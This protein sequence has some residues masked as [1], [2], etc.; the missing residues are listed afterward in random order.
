MLPE[1]AEMEPLNES[2][3]PEHA[4]SKTPSKIDFR[5]K[6]MSAVMT[7]AAAGFLVAIGV[8]FGPIAACFVFLGSGAG[9]VL[10]ACVY[11]KDKDLNSAK[12]N[13]E[14]GEMEEG[15]RGKPLNEIKPNNLNEDTQRHSEKS[16]APVVRVGGMKNPL[17]MGKESIKF[18][19]LSKLRTNTDNTFS[20][21][22]SLTPPRRDSSKHSD[23][24]L[25][26]P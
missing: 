6:F 24:E 21:K 10:C 23:K 11:D 17:S 5:D 15:T 19:D 18:T 22:N 2:S 8:A 1:K 16:T 4:R 9:L 7:G 3:A 12:K 25:L 26:L 13:K 14:L 20:Q